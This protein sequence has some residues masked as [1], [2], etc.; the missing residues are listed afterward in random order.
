MSADNYIL[1]IKEKNMWAGYLE[2]ASVSEPRYNA[3]AFKVKYIEDAIIHAQ[4]TDTEYGYIFKG[5]GEDV[6]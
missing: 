4:N 6:T 3:P 1:M 5:L 2:S